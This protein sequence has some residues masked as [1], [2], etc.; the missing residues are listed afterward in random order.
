MGLIGGDGYRT[1]PEA[2]EQLTKGINAAMS[3]L[4]ELGFDIEAQLG[5]GFDRLSLDAVECGDDGL[6]TVFSSFCDRWGWGVRTLMQDANTFS[7][8]LGLTA[9]NYYEQEQY[10]SDLLKQGVNAAFGDPTRSAED[11]HKTSWSKLKADVIDANTDFDY[12]PNSK[13][14]KESFQRTDDALR[15]F[16]HD[17]SASADRALNFGNDLADTAKKIT[18]AEQTHGGSDK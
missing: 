10:A 3:E 12:D 15:R 6:A 5:R 11:L 9:G 2:F 17:A 13:A 1:D 16:G 4:K 18:E 8:K 7:R 14:S